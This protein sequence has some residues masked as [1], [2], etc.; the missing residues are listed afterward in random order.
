MQNGRWE[1]Q[2]CEVRIVSRGRSFNSRIKLLG[3][4]EPQQGS[5]Q[6]ISDVFFVTAVAAFT[7]YLERCLVSQSPGIRQACNR[8]RRGPDELE[9][10]MEL[11]A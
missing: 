4:N 10:F 2:N 11:T 3:N 9:V 7:K 1:F 8:R 6:V 5:V